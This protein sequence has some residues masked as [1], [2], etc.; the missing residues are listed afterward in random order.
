[1]SECDLERLPLLIYPGEL[2]EDELHDARVHLTLCARCEQVHAELEAVAAQL[3][4]VPE[5]KMTPAERRRVLTE[6]ATATATGGVDDAGVRRALDLV[7]LDEVGRELGLGEDLRADLR[8]GVL[9]RVGLA[10]NDEDLSSLE[11]ELGAALDL[12][13]TPALSE[14]ARAGLREGVLARVGLT[15]S[16]ELE[17][18]EADFA[19]PLSLV[20]APV[21][22]EDARATL[23]EGVLA[24]VGLAPQHAEEAPADLAAALDGVEAPVLGADQRAELRESVLNEVGLSPTA[25]LEHQEADFAAAL[26]SVGAP[27]LSD[28]ERV[29][30]RE[31][32]LAR[33]GLRTHETASH[34]PVE[35]ALDLVEAP[36]LEAS[37]RE[38]LQ[39]EVTART[40]PAPSGTLIRFPRW[41]LAAA[42]A[43]LLS[44]T[45][46]L[47]Y[48]GTQQSPGDNTRLAFLE[49]EKL[50]RTADEIGDE[51][52]AAHLV[53]SARERIEQVVL[54][55]GAAPEVQRRA[56]RELMALDALSLRAEPSGHGE[57]I[58]PKPLRRSPESFLRPKREVLERYPESLAAHFVL[59][60]YIDLAAQRETPV[61]SPV[62]P[63]E[64][65]IASVVSSSLEADLDA[66]RAKDADVFR[67]DVTDLEKRFGAPSL[68]LT[69]RL[70]LLIQRGLHSAEQGDVAAARACYQEVLDL[71]AEATRLKPERPESRAAEIA[72]ELATKLAR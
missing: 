52:K 66:L 71:D 51:T 53:A 36:T 9:S 20:E 72:R 58:A 25:P 44:G 5:P 37:E 46:A 54:T 68:V 49:A 6:V 4:L 28:D 34:E 56:K 12:V 15:P 70:A 61:A 31:G 65:E 48:A 69:I 10:G 47:Y 38:Q 24:R 39:A 63:S 8:E 33:V 43:L 62:L 13:A 60:R 42:A 41:I 55:Q 21:L 30:L 23:R 29:R 64:A 32:V 67:V 1:M 19:A 14:D 16:R 3:D 18:E 40:A 27:S 11:S 59:R 17:H 7:G 50:F 26:D 2:S 45:A 22:G 35:K 57:G